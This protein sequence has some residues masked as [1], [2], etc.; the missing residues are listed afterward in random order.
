MPPLLERRR[1]TR[2]GSTFDFAIDNTAGFTVFF[3][4]VAA[5]LLQR[6]NYC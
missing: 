3:D 5:L 1:E 2:N 6:N 4:T